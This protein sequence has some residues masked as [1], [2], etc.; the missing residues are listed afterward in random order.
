M[1]LGARS[2]HHLVG[3]ARA[4]TK[5]KW[6]ALA[7]CPVLEG[8]LFSKLLTCFQ[9]LCAGLNACDQQVVY[10]YS[11]KGNQLTLLAIES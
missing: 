10:M 11:N 4:S 1:V 2:R 6:F 7:W 9:E 8:E 3:Q 5:L